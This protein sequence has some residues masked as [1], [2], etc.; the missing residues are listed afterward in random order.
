MPL[1]YECKSKLMSQNKNLLKNLAQSDINFNFW[2]LYP[3]TPHTI[4]SLHK[5]YLLREFFQAQLV[6]VSCSCYNKLPRTKW[7][8]TIAIYSLSLLQS[9][10]MQNKFYLAKIKDFAGSYSCWSLKW[11]EYILCFFYFLLATSILW[12]LAASFQSSKPTSSKVF[13]LPSSMYPFS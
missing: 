5:Y 12:L 3:S 6:I 7:I 8:K 9:R 11:G 10:K 1:P 2:P 13:I 4:R